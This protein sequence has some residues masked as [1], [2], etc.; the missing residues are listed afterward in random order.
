M[1]RLS[2]I[3]MLLAVLAFWPAERADAHAY[4]DRSVPSDQA[5]NIAAPAEVK[6]WF[7]EPIE[8][9]FS[10]LKLKDAQGQVVSG[11]TQ[12]ADGDIALVLALPALADGVYRVEWQVLAKDTHV[13]EGVITFGVGVPLTRTRPADPVVI[14][15]D[16]PPAPEPDPAPPAPA[17]EP[18]PADPAPA[19]APTPPEVIEDVRPTSPGMTMTTIAL[20]VL[21]LSA[22]VGLLLFVRGGRRPG[23]SS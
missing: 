22:V 3:A 10:T 8:T 4:V 13:T 2:G 6:V 1:K 21:G 15:D 23:A 17:P 11:T 14:G 7:T 20:L 18:P 5:E 19:L 16:P 12:T 9:R